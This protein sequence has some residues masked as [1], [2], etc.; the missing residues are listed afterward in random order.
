MNT[1]VNSFVLFLSQKGLVEGEPGESRENHEK[2]ATF[3]EENVFQVDASTPE[4]Q[5]KLEKVLVDWIKWLFSEM[6]AAEYV[7]QQKSNL[8]NFVMNRF[9]SSV[10]DLRSICTYVFLE[11]KDVKEAYSGGRSTQAEECPEM[12]YKKGKN[13]ADPFYEEEVVS[14]ASLLFSRC[15]M[16]SDNFVSPSVFQVVMTCLLQNTGARPDDLLRLSFRDMLRMEYIP[17]ESARFFLR[18]NYTKGR[19][20]P[21]DISVYP[22]LCNMTLSWPVA[23]AL[24]LSVMHDDVIKPILQQQ[25]R[26]EEGEHQ[27]DS[28]FGEQRGESDH[29]PNT[30]N[31]F[32]AL[33]RHVQRRRNDRLKN[34]LDPSTIGKEFK[35]V[36]SECIGGDTSTLSMYS[37]RKYLVSYCSNAAIH[38]DIEPFVSARVGHSR[39]FYNEMDGTGT[40]HTRRWIRSGDMD[41]RYR[42]LTHVGD[43]MVALISAHRNPKSF[44]NDHMLD[45]GIALLDQLHPSDD[46]L[47]GV[48]ERAF[49]SQ[50]IRDNVDR[51]TLK[52]LF[53]YL[54]IGSA[55]I[56]ECPIL[57]TITA[58]SGCERLV[59][60]LQ[61]LPLLPLPNFQLDFGLQVS[62][63]KVPYYQVDLNTGELTS[64]DLRSSTQ[65]SG[66][67]PPGP[68]EE[69]KSPPSCV[70]VDENESDSD[71]ELNID[72]G[73]RREDSPAEGFTGGS[74]NNYR[75][76]PP[77][78][79]KQQVQ[80]QPKQDNLQ[81]ARA[82]NKD[83]T[84]NI[85]K[86]KQ[87]LDA[88]ATFTEIDRRTSFVSQC[89]QCVHS[90]YN[91][92]DGVEEDLRLS[93]SEW[94]RDTLRDFKKKLQDKEW[95]EGDEAYRKVLS[96]II[97]KHI[98][99]CLQVK[100]LDNFSDM[101]HVE[102]ALKAV[103][104]K[105]TLTL[106]E[107]PKLDTL[108]TFKKFKK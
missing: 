98:K 79:V 61:Q 42:A 57:R 90:W 51:M 72:M 23:L 89:E 56:K 16:E 34:F 71:L 3:L 62:F 77:L 2:A 32:E 29:N 53:I 66:K 100:N 63:G 83:I 8:K 75:S 21:R 24:A 43:S 17:N 20:M 27:S 41:S 85:L 15:E 97:H 88:W 19:W 94:D 33:L 107:K 31:F 25:Q 22:N 46:T 4:I 87:A 55:F 76:N 69:Y 106:L 101:A 95:E 38:S 104:G 70:S 52:V 99:R 5:G 35:K 65:S 10:A 86:S 12:M 26:E 68:K 50:L 82:S 49:P 40:R 105:A 91:V 18:T 64:V 60:R 47:D 108:L 93:M 78:Y 80:K 102:V 11:S 13:F 73:K 81:A 103:F 30:L 14:I 1:A 59:E 39:A 6:K 92:P 28:E 44:T 37:Y 36:V 58:R 84:R 74:W 96:S 7:K 54:H 48:L 67:I 45:V 9:A